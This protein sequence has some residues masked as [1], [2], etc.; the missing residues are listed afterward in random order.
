MVLRLIDGGIPSFE[1]RFKRVEIE[2][3]EN[4]LLELKAKVKSGELEE[5]KAFKKR[6][7]LIDDLEMNQELFKKIITK[8]PGIPGKLIIGSK[9]GENLKILGVVSSEIDL[10]DEFKRS[11]KLIEGVEKDRF[12]WLKKLTKEDKNGEI[13]FFLGKEN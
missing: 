10:R 12:S 5:K 7:K 8:I 11:K 9:S 2:I 1:W 3:P 13:C 4:E 6:F